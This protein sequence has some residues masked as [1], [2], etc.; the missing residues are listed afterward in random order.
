MHRLTTVA[1][2]ALLCLSPIARADDLAKDVASAEAGNF[3][4]MLRVGL[5]YLSDD[6]DD[7]NTDGVKW[8]EMSTAGGN[9]TA[10]Y[11]LGA[12]YQDG[13]LVEQ[14]A[15]QALMNLTIAAELGEVRAMNRLA[16][17]YYVG[18]LVPA[19]DILAIKWGLCAMGLGSATAKANVERMKTEISERS[20]ALGTKAA[21]AWAKQRALKSK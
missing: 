10:Y 20:A 14:N 19:N 4:A 21:L 9:V 5:A 2:L 15:Q 18:K 11:N 6:N 13:T 17:I 8:L 1:M 12:M 3:D 7:N 16:G